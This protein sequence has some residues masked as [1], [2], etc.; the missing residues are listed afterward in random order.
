[1]SFEVRARWW[2]SSWS[3]RWR[4]SKSIREARSGSSFGIWFY[5]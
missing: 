5:Q 4:Y 1:M 2:V 3:F